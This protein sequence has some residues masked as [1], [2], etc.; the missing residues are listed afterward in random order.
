M[1]NLS[2]TKVNSQ[3]LKSVELSDTGAFP[4]IGLKYKRLFL[5]MT[6]AFSLLT[7]GVVIGGQYS[8]YDIFI[9]SWIGITGVLIIYGVTNQKSKNAKLFDKAKHYLSHK[10]NLFLITQFVVFALPFAVITLTQFSLFLLAIAAVFGVSYAFEFEAFSKSV[11][12]KK[13][14]IIKNALIGV[15]W[16]MLI[17]IGSG[18]INDF[19][20]FSL[21]AFMSSQIFIG[22]SM[23]DLQD[24]E[25]DKIKGIKTIPSLIGF[26]NSFKLFHVLNVSTLL[27]VFLEPLS[28][29]M[30]VIFVAVVTWKALNLYFLKKNNHSEFWGQTMNILTCLFLLILIITR[31]IWIF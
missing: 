28:S 9:L 25:G 24:V 18:V 7:S 14:P 22:S 23:R 1:A 11:Q 21:A 6:A 31:D 30:A 20:A 15:A 2:E 13:I 17:L 4:I 29:S 26:S 27:F 3:L 8:R 19:T 16:A 5:F 10:W 12:L